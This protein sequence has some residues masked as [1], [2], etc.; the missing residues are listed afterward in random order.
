MAKKFN[1]KKLGTKAIGVSVGAVGAKVLDK[2]L[3]NLDPKLRGAGKIA[4]GAVLPNFM[5]GEL[6]ENIGSGIIAVGALDLVGGFAPGLVSGVG[7]TS[8]YIYDDS[9]S[10][11]EDDSVLSGD[12]GAVLEGEEE[13]EDM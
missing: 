8:E 13:E 6:S 12:D 4:L 1:L 9:V 10:G 2:P 11:Y 5:K 7:E 3:Q